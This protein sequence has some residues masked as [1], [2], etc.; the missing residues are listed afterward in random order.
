MIEIKI[1]KDLGKHFTNSAP[2]VALWDWYAQFRT[3]CSFLAPHA[4]RRF[5]YRGHICLVFEP[6]GIRCGRQSSILSHVL[7]VLLVS[8]WCMQPVRF[9][10]DELVP[11]FPTGN[12]S[13]N[14]TAAH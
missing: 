6:L 11:G 13:P 14:G 4:A 5:D 7:S 10:V 9:P 3:H 8:F 2:F 12:S 1:L